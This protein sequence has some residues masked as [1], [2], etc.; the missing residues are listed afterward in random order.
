MSLRPPRSLSGQSASS[1]FNPLE[2]ELASERADALG[3]QG[4]KVEATL[5][6]LAEC[7]KDDRDRGE[8]EKLVD[9][10]ADAVW[11]LFIQRE[12]CG[13]RNN[14]DLVAWY[15]IPGEVLARLGAIRK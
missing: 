2:Y 11:A 5:A 12:V 4:R 1:T 14:R 15:G 8:R 6:R 9:D 13:L 3:R 10:A 7:S